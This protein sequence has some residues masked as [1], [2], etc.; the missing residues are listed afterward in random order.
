MCF[1]SSV[2]STV[3]YSLCF[4]ISNGAQ[5]QRL[6]EI[7]AANCECALTVRMYCNADIVKASTP[8]S[9]CNEAKL[10]YMYILQVLWRRTIAEQRESLGWTQ[11]ESGI[12][13]GFINAYPQCCLKLRPRLIFPRAVINA[14]AYNYLRKYMCMVVSFQT[15]FGELFVYKLS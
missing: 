15:V 7:Y 3:S 9:V 8:W 5:L 14:A 11:S 2:L 4:T 12:V 6:Y 13:A 10:G 1:F